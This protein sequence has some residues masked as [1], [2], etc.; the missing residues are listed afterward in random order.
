MIL[1]GDPRKSLKEIAYTKIKE[2]IASGLYRPGKELLEYELVEQLGV[3]RT[4]IREAF[5]RLESEGFVRSIPRKGVIVTRLD[6][7]D[8]IQISQMR[9]A[10]E[11]MAARL[12]CERLDMVKLLEIEKDFPQNVQLLND[13]EQKQ[14]Y[15]NGQILHD[16]ILQSSGNE[17]II[18]TVDSLKFKI[19]GMTLLAKEAPDRYINGLTEHLEIIEALKEKNPDEAE[20]RMRKHIHNSLNS[21]VSAYKF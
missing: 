18:K 8:I 9:E 10:L 17:L 20:R 6:L 14:S 19:N 3:S 16:F 4:P 7:S 11:G 5:S 2:G 21:L 13:E 15:E 12:A 1:I